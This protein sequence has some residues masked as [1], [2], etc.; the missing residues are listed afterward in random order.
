MLTSSTLLRVFVQDDSIEVNGFAILKSSTSLSM[1]D[2]DL[3]IR[4]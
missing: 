4:R 3:R 1:K 2:F